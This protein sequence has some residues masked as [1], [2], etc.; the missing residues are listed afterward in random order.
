[1]GWSACPKLDVTSFRGPAH[2]V[3]CSFMVIFNKA[4]G[5]IRS[6]NWA[7]TNL[8]GL[9]C[10]CGVERDFAK[11][12]N[13]R[14][15]GHETSTEAKLPRRD[16]ILL[17]LISLLTIMLMVVSTESLSRRMFSVSKT[18]IANG[19]VV[20]NDPAIGIQGVQNTVCWE[21]SPEGQLAEFRFNGCGHRAGMECGPK[22]PGTYRIVLTGGSSRAHRR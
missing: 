22:S 5:R 1:M 4:H 11:M 2:L 16:W 19:C 3:V 6:R 14:S 18:S 7:A 9:D 15:T 10:R 17:P 13:F 21:K 8:I 12:T 20:R